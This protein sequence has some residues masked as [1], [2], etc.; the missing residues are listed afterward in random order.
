LPDVNVS[1]LQRLSVVWCGVAAA[2][3]SIKSASRLVVLCSHESS[4]LV[5]RSHA[6]RSHR[7]PILTWYGRK[8]TNSTAYYFIFLLH[9]GWRR[10]VIVASVILSLVLP[11]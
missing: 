2:D 10:Y 4:G 7:Q 1:G 3:E 5:L 8:Y 6:T 9:P 11:G